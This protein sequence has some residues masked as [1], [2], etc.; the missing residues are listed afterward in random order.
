NFGTHNAAASLGGAY[1]RFDYFSTFSRSDTRGSLPNDFFHNATY[2][3]NFG[4]RLLPKTDLRVTY[5]RNWTA[6]GLPN[7]IS[8]YGIA[9]D[10]TQK[11]QNTFFSSSL[12]NQ[13]TSRWRNS[14]QF[15]YGQFVSDYRN[16]SPTGQLSSFGDYLG[17]AV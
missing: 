6:V 4:V 17:N 3:G 7:G 15:A 12:Q 10:S 2:A 5:R 16:P 14:F 11:N 8:L 1:R 13:T 9:D